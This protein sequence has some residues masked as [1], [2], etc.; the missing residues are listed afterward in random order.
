MESKTK[1]YILVTVCGVSLYAVL[2][3]LPTV[4][5]YTGQFVELVLPIIVGSILALFI[6]IPMGRI[7]R[8]LRK[9]LKKATDKQIR[10]LSFLLTILSVLLVLVFVLNPHRAAAII[11]SLR[12]Y[13]SRHGNTLSYFS[14]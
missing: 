3:N 14:A 10:I 6:N 9:H 8:S 13:K 11:E 7:E 4:L 2:M 5:K 12:K 1:Q